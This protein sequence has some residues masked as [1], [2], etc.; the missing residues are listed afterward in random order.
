M[1]ELQ[2]VNKYFGAVQVLKDISFTV[3][4]GEIVGFLG[5]NGAGKTTTMRILNG[6]MPAT[7]GKAKVVG[8]EVDQD[9]LEVKRRIGYLPENVSLYNDMTVTEYLTFVA[10]AKRIPRREVAGKVSRACLQCGVGEVTNRLIG[11]LSK[12]YKQRVGLAQ[13]IINEPEVLIMDEPTTGLDPAQI[14]EIRELIKSF[15]GE[16]TIIISTHILQEVS[17]TCQRVIIINDGRIVAEDSLA[18]LTGSSAPGGSL[19]IRVAGD[20]ASLRDKLT[21]LDGV[22]SIKESASEEPGVTELI[23]A[24]EKDR[25]IRRAVAEIT[26][27]SGCGLLELR[28]IR[29]SLE[30]I[31]MQTVTKNA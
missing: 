29:L 6:F 21:A 13:A 5:P 24:A 18:N 31:F 1:I 3:N 17:A 25:D 12:G 19:M 27:G 30:E 15:A 20:V 7:S 28:P 11:P 10:Q 16:H 2:Q 4:K 8:Y 14:I 9:P 22:V 23:V 26:V